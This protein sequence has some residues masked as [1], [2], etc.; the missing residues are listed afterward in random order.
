MIWPRQLAGIGD[1]PVHR[2]FRRGGVC[3]R[4]LVPQHAVGVPVFVVHTDTVAGV[5]PT[6]YRSTGI[7]STFQISS[8]YSAIARSD[9]NFPLRAALMIDIRD[10]VSSSCHA[11]LTLAW[12]ST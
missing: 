2:V 3:R 4:S 5:V 1:E 6:G 11:A 9:E 7:A 8:Q 10:Q 12:Q